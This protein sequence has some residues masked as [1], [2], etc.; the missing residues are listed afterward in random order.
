MREKKEEEAKE[1]KKTEK[2]GGEGGRE[3]G[4]EKKMISNFSRTENWT[5]ESVKSGF[6]SQLFHLDMR[7]GWLPT[8][9]HPISLLP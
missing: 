7:E 4:K 6:K 8:C 2:K 1:E 3:E 5:V 9:R